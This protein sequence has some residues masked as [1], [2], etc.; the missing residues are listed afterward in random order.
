MSPESE[1]FAREQVRPAVAPAVSATRLVARRCAA[2]ASVAPSCA[3]AEL[4]AERCH[5]A[6]LTLGVRRAYAR[7]RPVPS[8]SLECG[9][10][11]SRMVL[12]IPASSAPVVLSKYAAA[13]AH[14]I[15]IPQRANTTGRLSEAPAPSPKRAWACLLYTSDAADE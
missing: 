12:A 6:E 3:F 14:R 9:G 1:G 15:G 8:A 10:Q 7:V 11:P 5:V 4:P 13:A 2:A